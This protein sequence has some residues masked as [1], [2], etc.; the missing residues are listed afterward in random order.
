MFCPTDFGSVDE[1]LGKVLTQY[2]E[3]P[4]LIHMI[5]TYLRQVEIVE[6][7]ICDLPESFDLETAVGDQLTIIG[8]RLGFP[9]THCVCDVQPV[10]GFSCKVDG[11]PVDGFGSDV[12]WQACADVGVSFITI[13]S[14]D[15]YRKFLFVR[16]YQVTRKFRRADLQR[17]LETFWGE[18]ASIL[19][20]RHGCVTVTPGRVL[21]PAEQA[22]I[23]LVPRVLPTPLGVTVRFHFGITTVL[24]F[25]DGWGGL[26]DG[27]GTGLDLTTES[28]E[29]I[30]VEDGRNLEVDNLGVGSDWLCSI[31]VKAYDC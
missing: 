15:L 30:Q 17:S 25:G 23:Q 31:D 9:R 29:I 20:A 22:V 26:C 10:F 5:R 7:S 13:E 6:Q 4:K 16:R 12:T 21:T 18:Q 14:D 3:S 2:R 19:S 27:I 1:R 8:K 11:L 24:G 28:D